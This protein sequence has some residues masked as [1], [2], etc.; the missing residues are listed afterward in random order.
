MR[1]NDIVVAASRTEKMRDRGNVRRVALLATFLLAGPA[2]ATSVKLQC[3]MQ[4]EAGKRYGLLSVV[5]DLDA[6][7]VEV[8]AAKAPGAVWRWRDG[9]L[10]PYLLKG[11][12][13][14]F[15]AYPSVRQF[16]RVTKA[17]VT[18][19]WRSD[20]DGE[21]Q[22]GSFNRSAIDKPGTACIW[23]HTRAFSVS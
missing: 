9:E 14:L 2:S 4:G 17:T 15:P 19:G 21:G 7:S 11:P 18:F 23:H 8:A 5:V 1:I 13:W 10:A 3:A 12:Q 20:E 16:V 6:R 22:V